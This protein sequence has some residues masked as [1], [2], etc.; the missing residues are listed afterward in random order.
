M[1]L[2]EA[3]L[4]AFAPARLK[5]MLQDLGELVEPP[6]QTVRGQI[7]P[8]AALALAAVGTLICVVVPVLILPQV[9]IL[10]EARDALWCVH[11]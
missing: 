6:V 10:W 8:W 3:F 11:A 2:D 5:H 4:S 7:I 1:D 9:T